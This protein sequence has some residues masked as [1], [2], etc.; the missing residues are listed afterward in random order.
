MLTRTLPTTLLQTFC[1]T[2]LISKVIVENII[3]PDDKR[4]A[5][6]YQCVKNGRNQVYCQLLE[7]DLF[8]YNL[9]LIDQVLSP[10]ITHAESNS[11][12]DL[13]NGKITMMMVMI[14]LK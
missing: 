14:M 3:D 1:K 5:T 10:P 13:D 12:Q 7:T 8:R 6:K 2:I 9:S 4:R 11:F